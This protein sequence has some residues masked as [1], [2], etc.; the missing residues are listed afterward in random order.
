MRRLLRVLTLHSFLMPLPNFVFLALLWSIEPYLAILAVYRPVLGFGIL[1][2]LRLL[3]PVVVFLRLLLKRLILNVRLE[4]VIHISL[5][6]P[7]LL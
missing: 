7:Q 6:A 3:K 4:S 5:Q 1:L 2:R